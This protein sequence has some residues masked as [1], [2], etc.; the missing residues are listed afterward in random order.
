MNL[1]RFLALLLSLAGSAPAFAVEPF[2]APAVSQGSLEVQL[3]PTSAAAPGA[4]KLVTFG[5]PFPRGSITSAG[6]ASLRVLGFSKREISTIL[7][8]EQA[9]QVALALP[10]GLVIGYYMAVGMMSG[11]DPEAYRFPIR[12]STR[13]YLYAV[14]VT[15]VSAIVSA[16]ILRGKIKRLD[17]IAVLK[18]RE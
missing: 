13:T 3:V 4:E 10:L 11:V 17:L 7:F 9:V 16:L 8:G 15:V 5:V 1:N 12:V 6:L 18:T 14:F 2:L